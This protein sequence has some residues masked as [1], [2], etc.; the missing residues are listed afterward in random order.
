M[1]AIV[2]QQQ[3]FDRFVSEIKSHLTK[4]VESIKSTVIERPMCVKEAA[5]Y[6]RINEATLH[7]WRKDGYLPETLVHRINGSVYFLP[8]ELHAFIKR[9]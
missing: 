5:E 9:K 8:S 2:L 3:D 4:E 7:R 1:N 6:L